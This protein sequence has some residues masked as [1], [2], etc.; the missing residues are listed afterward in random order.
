[1]KIFQRTSVAIDFIEK[2]LIGL[3]NRFLS[4]DPKC[5]LK[6]G[7]IIFLLCKI[8]FTDDLANMMKLRITSDEWKTFMDYMEAIKELRGYE[9]VRV[10][11]YHLST[12]SFFKLTVKN[13]TLALE[14]GSPQTEMNPQIDSSQN[15]IFWN[16]IRDEIRLLEK[17]E[18]VDLRN[19]NVVKEEAFRPFEKMFPERGLLT[20]TLHEF[21]MLKKFFHEPNEPA[22]S[23]I[24]QKLV[25][26]ACRDFLTTDGKCSGLQMNLEEVDSDED[27]AE[28]ST[29]EKKSMKSEKQKYGAKLKDHKD[30][31]RDS[32]SDSCSEK[33]YRRMIRSLGYHSQNV[34]QGIGAHNFFSDKLKKCYGIDN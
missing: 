30:F 27:S 19:L 8:Y 23:R 21:D 24:T 13:K 11:F 18:I 2:V 32:S 10:M 6:R 14:Y 15:I 22:P 31:E 16:E 29:T 5:H 17:S 4:E 34:M 12:E 7:A 26:Q 1:M 3:K 20:D 9:T 28:T 33:D 25:S